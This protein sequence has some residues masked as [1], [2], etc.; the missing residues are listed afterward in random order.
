MDCPKCKS[1]NRVKDGKIRDKQRYRCKI[2]GYHYTVVRKSDVKPPE[3]RRLALVLYLE[4]FGL[5]TIGRILKISY[6][7]VHLWVKEWTLHMPLPRREKPV[8]IVTPD[9]MPACIASKKVDTLHG[10]LLIDLDKNSSVLCWENHN[11]KSNH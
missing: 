1:S 8:K 5:R 7:T 6:G 11:C 4:G 9:Q 2:C 3:T 10:L